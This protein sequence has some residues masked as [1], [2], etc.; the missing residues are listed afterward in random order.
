MSTKKTDLTNSEK[1][2][3]AQLQ[4]N[5]A[6]EQNRIIKTKELAKAYSKVSIEQDAINKNKNVIT[7]FAA[8]NKEINSLLV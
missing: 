3:Y 8:V 6:S 5:I 4:K 7:G 2:E 1:K